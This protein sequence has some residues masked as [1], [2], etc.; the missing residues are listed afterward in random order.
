M[1]EELLTTNQLAEKLKVNP[2]TIRRMVSSGK[3]PHV[4]LGERDFR[5]YYSKVI[6]ALEVK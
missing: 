3:I 5:F 6:E 2:Q 4:K 1:N